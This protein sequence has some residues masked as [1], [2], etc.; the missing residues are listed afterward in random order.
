MATALRHHIANAVAVQAV[1]GGARGA[2]FD[3]RPHRKLGAALAHILMNCV[4]GE[5]RER[6][7]LFGDDGLDLGDAERAR[8]IQH[9]LEEVIRAYALPTLILRKRDGLAPWPVPI[10]CSG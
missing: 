7:R 9:L 4:V 5:A 2:P 1:G 3:H 6:L 10:T 8:R